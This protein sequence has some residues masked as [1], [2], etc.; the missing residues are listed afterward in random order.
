MAGGSRVDGGQSPAD[1]ITLRNQL[2]DR[3]GDVR[4]ERDVAGSAWVVVTA[5][6]AGKANRG[7]QR[8]SPN[9]LIMR[10]QNSVA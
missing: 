1:G 7:D 6:G 4:R 3:V 8:S 9:A 5:G 2:G 10:Y